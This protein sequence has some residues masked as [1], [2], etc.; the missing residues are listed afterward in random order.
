MGGFLLAPLS[1]RILDQ[2]RLI[3][4]DY[5][6][7]RSRNSDDFEVSIFLTETNTRHSLLYKHKHFRDRTQTKLTSNSTKL[8]GGDSKDAPIDVDSHTADISVPSATIEQQEREGTTPIRILREDDDD[9]E[10]VPLYDIPSIDR[11][12]TNAAAESGLPQATRASKRRREPSGSSIRDNSDGVELACCA[13]NPSQGTGASANVVVDSEDEDDLFVTDNDESDAEARRSATP[14][15]D[16]DEVNTTVPP[17]AK[18]RRKTAAAAAL[19]PPEEAQRDD[20]KKL[21]MDISYEGFSIYGRVLCLVVKR[22]D[23]VPKGK[24]KAVATT[25][26]GSGS[27]SSAAAA[28]GSI[29]GGPQSAA[30]EGQAVMENWITST[31]MPAD[32]IAE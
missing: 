2:T 18:R 9:N 16:D 12:E 17:P 23:G 31:Q 20:K 6:T 7:H 8:T 5:V 1:Q 11:D 13:R 19:A 30:R 27:S 15:V 26:A 24:G 32:V 29:R 21:A 3:G 25:T 4:D 14:T 28:R 10:V 22:R